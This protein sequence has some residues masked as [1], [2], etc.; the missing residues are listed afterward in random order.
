MPGVLVNSVISH[1]AP[2]DGGLVNNKISWS[3]K[4]GMLYITLQILRALWIE[5]CSNQTLGRFRQSYGPGRRARGGNAHGEFRV[6]F[7]TR[8]WRILAASSINSA[9]E[10]LN[11]SIHVRDVLCER[12]KHLVKDFFPNVESLLDLRALQWRSASSLAR[13]H[14]APHV[15][16]MGK[17][18]SQS[19][20]RTTS[21]RGIECLD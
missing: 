18:T 14:Q 20:H 8:L 2:W 3:R 9:F 11:Y 12:I 7:D 5:H 13:T 15:R 1:L 6:L 10:W 4:S 19:Y 21:F 16:H 17:P